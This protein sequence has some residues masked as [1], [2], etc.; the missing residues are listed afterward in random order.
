[1]EPE[2]SLP[3]S[4]APATCPWCMMPPLETFPPG[5]PSG[6]VFYIRIVLS[7]EE[8]SRP[9]IFRNRIVSR[10]GV[11]STSPNPQTGGPPIVGCPRLLSQFIR[12]YPSYRRPFLHPQPGDAPCRGDRDPQTQNKGRLC[13]KIAMLFYFCHLKKLV[14]PET[15][16]P[17][18]VLHIFQPKTLE[19]YLDPLGGEDSSHFTVYDLYIYSFNNTSEEISP[20]YLLYFQVD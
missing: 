7:P 14:R 1:M 13:W 19:T 9:R 5:D 15:F 12:S 20:S 18:Y 8:A 6:G 4:Q 17:Y 2:S 16:G 11:V 10:G 3:Y